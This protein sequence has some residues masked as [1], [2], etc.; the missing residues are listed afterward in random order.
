MAEGFVHC[1]I[2][3]QQVNQDLINA[4]IDSGCQDE[5]TPKTRKPATQP[6]KLFPQKVTKPFER[7]ATPN[8]DLL[9]DGPLRKKLT[10]HG[11]S[12]AGTR[13]LQVL[14]HSEWITQ[15]NANCDAT[16]PKTKSEL[17]REM[18]VWERT[19]GGQSRSNSSNSGAQ[20][21]DKDFD[22]MAWSTKHDGD[23]RDLIVNARK[24]I[25]KV[26]RTE[27]HTPEEPATPPPINTIRTDGR[28][29]PM[30]LSPTSFAMRET[31]PGDMRF[32]PN[33]D[34]DAPPSLL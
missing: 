5:P 23:F 32:Q 20:I 22:A 6:S 26:A 17:K 34:P 33:Y 10:D 12:T 24:K 7:L 13:Q 25:P 15:W 9:K 18:E 19:Q 31:L 28:Y 30:H 1:P 14:R 27:E 3:Q 16:K 11:L 21:R 2:C 8:Y 29:V 4:H